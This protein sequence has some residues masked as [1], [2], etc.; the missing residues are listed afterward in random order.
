MNEYTWKQKA[1]WLSATIFFALALLDLCAIDPL[2]PGDPWPKPGYG[3]HTLFTV[4]FMDVAVSL[5]FA[6]ALLE[7][8]ALFR[9]LPVTG[10]RLGIIMT[11]IWRA[12]V[13]VMVLF[14]VFSLL[15]RRP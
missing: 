15:S 2:A 13:L 11:Y 14:L 12:L 4:V 6:Y 5:M 1:V 10:T 9:G 8:V 3:H 7:T